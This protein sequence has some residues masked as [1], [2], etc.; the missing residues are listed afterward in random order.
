MSTN[1][2]ISMDSLIKFIN[3]T[4]AEEDAR[5]LEWLHANGKP[6]ATLPLSKHYWKVF[7][8]AHTA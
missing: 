1:T 6:K 7:K 4:S 2:V 5:A 8:D 3:A